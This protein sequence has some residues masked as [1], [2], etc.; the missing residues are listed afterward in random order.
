MCTGWQL[1]CTS[2]MSD[3][4]YM[5]SMRQVFVWTQHVCCHVI[6]RIMW[7]IHCT[8]DPVSC[9]ATLTCDIWTYLSVL[10]GNSFLIWSQCV[11]CNF[12]LFSRCFSTLFWF[13]CCILTWQ[14]QPSTFAFE[15][16]ATHFCMRTG[17]ELPHYMFVQWKICAFRLYY[18]VLTWQLQHFFKCI[19]ICTFFKWSQ[20][21]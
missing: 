16:M 14:I 21:V 6:G 20:C 4:I 10:N 9:F 18:L 19:T 7:Q 2:T 17:C 13:L 12:R 3:A 15:H 11:H 1:I 8:A 5:I